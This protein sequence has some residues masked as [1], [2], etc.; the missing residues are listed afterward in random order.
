MASVLLNL[1]VK[2]TE[3]TQDMLNLDPFKKGKELSMFNAAFPVFF[4]SFS[5]LEA[6]HWS[7]LKWWGFGLVLAFEVDGSGFF[8]CLQIVSEN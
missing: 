7:S 4:P 6:A 8:K 3:I 1:S 5:L 2:G